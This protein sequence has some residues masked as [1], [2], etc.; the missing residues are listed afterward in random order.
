MHISKSGNAGNI[1]LLTWIQPVLL[2]LLSM[3]AKPLKGAK[4]KWSSHIDWDLSWVLGI[5]TKRDKCR[6]HHS[7]LMEK[8]F[9]REFGHRRECKGHR[10]G[11][12]P[13]LLIDLATLIYVTDV[14][15]FYI[16]IT[17]YTN[18]EEIWQNSLSRVKM[19]NCSREIY[20]CEE[21]M[22]DDTT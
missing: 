8:R 20:L 7:C 16:S 1:S 5:Q 11:W 17:V 10:M 14:R 21:I 15:P 18:V 2:A 9:L 6:N 22:C 12:T 3:W 4:E 13:L 19:Q